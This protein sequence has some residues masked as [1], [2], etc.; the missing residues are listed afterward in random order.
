MEGMGEMAIECEEKEGGRMEGVRGG[1]GV[2]VVVATKKIQTWFHS[3][4]AHT[5]SVTMAAT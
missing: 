1:N 5:H 3:L 4:Y 2:D